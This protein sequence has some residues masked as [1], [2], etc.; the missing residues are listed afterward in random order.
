ME[1]RFI[2]NL[3]HNGRR[4][5]VRWSL[6]GLVFALAVCLLAVFDLASKAQASPLL[7]VPTES[8]TPS[9]TSTPLVISSADSETMPTW[10]STPTPRRSTAMALT[11]QA[12]RDLTQTRVPTTPSSI[13]TLTRTP[14]ITTTY[15][16]KVFPTVTLRKWPTYTYTPRPTFT[17]IP[18]LD[19]RQTLE[20]LHHIYTLTAEY[21]EKFTQTAET[22]NYIAVADVSTPDPNTIVPSIVWT[23]S[24]DMPLGVNA[25]WSKDGLS[26][27]FEGSLSDHRRIYTLQIPDEEPV[28]VAGQNQQLLNENPP[29]NNKDNIQ[30]A[31][32]PDGHWIV[33]SSLSVEDRSRHHLF[34]V[35]A[36]ANPPILYQVTKGLYN[37]EFQPSWS[38]D[39]KSI[40]FISVYYYTPQIYTLGVGWLNGG[41]HK[42]VDMYGADPLATLTGINVNTE[43]APRY[44]MDPD[45]P[46][47]VFSG[48]GSGPRQIYV[49][50]TDGSNVIQLLNTNYGY[51]FPDW[52]P[53]C[54]K[55]IFIESAGRT[56]ISTL[57][58]KWLFRDPQGVEGDPDRLIDLG[59]DVGLLSSPHFSPNGLRVVFVQTYLYAPTRTPSPTSP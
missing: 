45:K 44:C 22:E 57:S 6:I 30:P 58:M 37:E 2:P 27:L 3:K 10:T 1:A 53:D 51:S 47:I 29:K 59:D 23:A 55:I 28:Q 26:L 25:T 34:I 32:S 15:Y 24:P 7:L 43:T 54:N 41:S 36:D 40:I 12:Q 49:M 33:F 52:S 38:P 18:S 39:G 19:Q 9:P 20:R 56:R 42:V 4:P 5:A 35:S 16:Y 11:L 31:L 8:P 46:W 14:S 50:K 48:R 17:S 13:Y 21:Y